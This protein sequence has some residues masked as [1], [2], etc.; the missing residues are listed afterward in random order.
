ML[1]TSL[2]NTFFVVVWVNIHLCIL[3]VT[4]NNHGE[5]STPVLKFSLRFLIILVCCKN[6]KFSILVWSVLTVLIK[7]TEIANQIKRALPFQCNSSVLV[8]K[9]CEVRCKYI[10]KHFIFLNC[11]DRNFK[12][13]TVISSDANYSTIF[14]KFCHFKWKYK[15]S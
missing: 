5:L 14:V 11:W 7:M 15:L 4:T 9:E 6:D 3:A 8:V 12:R 2:K 10:G 13:P 1:W